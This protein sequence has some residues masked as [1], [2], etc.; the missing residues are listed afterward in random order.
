MGRV[1]LERKPLTFSNALAHE[2]FAGAELLVVAA[3][4][5]RE[6]GHIGEQRSSRGSNGRAAT[7]TV[8]PHVA[9]AVATPESGS[10]PTSTTSSSKHFGKPT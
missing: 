6:A 2:P 4:R 1:A 7:G 3:P 8:M 10:N 5:R 9:F